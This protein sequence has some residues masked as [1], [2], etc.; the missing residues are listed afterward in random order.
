MGDNGARNS[1][2]ERCISEMD[3]GTWIPGFGPGSIIFSLNLSKLLNQ[4]SSP[5][6]VVRS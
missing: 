2:E 4:P 1:L 3:S 5:L 6:S